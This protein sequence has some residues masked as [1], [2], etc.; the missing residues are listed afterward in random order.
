MTE[1]D[2]FVATG[3]AVVG[4]EV[5]PYRQKDWLDLGAGVWGKLSGMVA[6][7]GLD[8]INAL[9]AVPN[10]DPNLSDNYK[11]TRVPAAP[12]TGVNG[13]GD[14][15]GVRGIGREGVRG[16]GDAVGVHG[17]GQ[18][19]GVRGEGP[20]GVF[21]RDRSI[22]TKLHLQQAGVKGQSNDGFGVIGVSASNRAGV[23]GLAANIPN[24]SGHAIDTKAVPQICLPAIALDTDDVASELPRAGIAGDLVAVLPPGGGAPDSPRAPRAQ[25]WFCVSTGSNDPS[26]TGATWTMIQLGST[27]TV[28]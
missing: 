12:G 1:E 7:G 17:E 24:S 22:S 14:L 3:P 28:P 11:I 10:P 15:I 9:M 19:W 8:T 5:G 13:L 26:E 23:F 21:G 25:L 27:I 4:F 6:V 20:I 16:E 2:R 18:E